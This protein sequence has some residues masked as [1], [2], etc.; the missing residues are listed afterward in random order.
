MGCGV[1]TAVSV[2]TGVP[3]GVGVNISVERTGVGALLV[4]TWRDGTV[5]GVVVAAF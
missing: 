5:V 4:V 2:V 1:W 3:A